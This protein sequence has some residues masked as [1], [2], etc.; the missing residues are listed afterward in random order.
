M[1]IIERVGMDQIANESE[2]RTQTIID[3]ALSKGWTVNTPL[4][5]NRRGGSVMI[6]LPD[7]SAMVERLAER[8]VFVDCRPGAGLRLS[9][10]FF[11]TDEEVAEALDVLSALIQ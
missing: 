11:N 9:P 5:R 3:F 4:E 6:G 1:E 7:A 10:H 8:R 2:R